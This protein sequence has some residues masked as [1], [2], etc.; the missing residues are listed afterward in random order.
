MASA[1]ALIQSIRQA[2]RELL[3]SYEELKALRGEYDA[4]GGE[5]FINSHFLDG[6]GQPRTDLD[7]TKVELLN[8]LTSAN[9]IRLFIEDNFHHT[10]LYKLK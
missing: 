4:V 10:N 2:T 9:A 5:T 3:D 1:S 7:I 6:Q 8:A